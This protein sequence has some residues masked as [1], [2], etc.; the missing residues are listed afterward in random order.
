MR[1]ISQLAAGFDQLA[2]QLA[3]QEGY[4]LHTVIPGPLPDFE[5]DVLQY[6][7]SRFGSPRT[8]KAQARARFQHLIAES[9]RLLQLDRKAASDDGSFSHEDYAQAGEVI[10]SHSDVVMVLI[11]RDAQATLG[12][13][14]WLEAQA[15]ARNLPVIHVPLETPHLAWLSWSANGR[16]E[17]AL[18]LG[19][20]KNA[21]DPE[22]FAAPLDHN[23]LGPKFDLA[24]TELGGWEQRVVGQL[25]LAHNQG[26]WENRWRLGGEPLDPRP[27]WTKVSAQVDHDFKA[28]KVWA[29]HRAS[30]MA[31]LARGSFMVASGLGL[32]AILGALLGR[33]TETFSV[34]GEVLELSCLALLF[35]LIS[36]ASR[37][38]WRSQWLSARQ[39]ER[40]LDQAAWLALLG[41]S[42]A[43]RLP[44]D[45]GRF[46]I[47]ATSL[48][49]NAVFR[50]AV[51]AASFPTV[52]LT[53]DYRRAVHMLALDNLVTSQVNYYRDEVDFHHRSDHALEKA[54]YRCVALAAAISA[55][56]LIATVARNMLEG[57]TAPVAAKAHD[58][59]VLILHHVETGAAILGAMLP[60]LAAALSAIRSHGEYEQIASRYQGTAEGLQP[61]QAFLA[62][63]LPDARL[64][65]APAVLSSDVLANRLEEATD[66]LVQEVMGWRSILQ[67]KTIEPT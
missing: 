49:A 46:Q 64:E 16:R 29:D 14:R 24:A 26:A 35:W 31:D 42:H 22:V 30:G 6:A 60:A 52:S 38:K 47:D 28:L 58:L 17:R 45:I 37:F 51:R 48:W 18:L 4:A 27:A 8:T 67:T 33:L 25:D 53:N 9:Q 7:A 57:A 10:L 20:D 1:L 41:R 44:P 21:I 54:V 11:H 66:L 13:T 3:L 63:H 56:L 50:A 59:L 34:A 62:A 12:G 19:E 61:I 65:D 43:Y 32:I 15:V 5:A 23:L 55:S 2:A 39:I 40:R 36:R